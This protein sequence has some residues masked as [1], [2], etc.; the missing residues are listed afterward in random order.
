MEI[1]PGGAYDGF[2]AVL[3]A[4]F[5][6]VSWDPRGVGASTAVKCFANQTPPTRSSSER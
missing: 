4:R 3:R 5:D 1:L 6:I 2:P